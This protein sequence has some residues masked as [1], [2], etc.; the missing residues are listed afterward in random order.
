[1]GLHVILILKLRVECSH[2][3]FTNNR[4]DIFFNVDQ[5]LPINNNNNKPKVEEITYITI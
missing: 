3:I 4:K 1:M 5:F 2:V